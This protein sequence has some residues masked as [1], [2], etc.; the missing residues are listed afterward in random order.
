MPTTVTSS[1]WLSTYCRIG[2]RGDLKSL[3]RYS[4]FCPAEV[5]QYRIFATTVSRML[6]NGLTR[7]QQ[8]SDSRCYKVISMGLCSLLPLV[9]T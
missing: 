2:L 6:E 7:C 3:L 8:H 5:L 9:S 4:A 1:L